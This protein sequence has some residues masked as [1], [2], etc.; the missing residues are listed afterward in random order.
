MKQQYIL[1]AALFTATAMSRGGGGGGS[2]GGGGG[3][4]SRGGGGGGGR[5]SGGRGGDSYDSG[6]SGCI[7]NS[8]CRGDGEKCYDGVC[9]V[10]DGPGNMCGGPD[11]DD[12][13][14]EGF[15]CNDK[16]TRCVPIPGTNPDQGPYDCV[17]DEDC[18]R[19]QI[20]YEGDCVLPDKIP[21]TEAP[22][23]T[24]N[25]MCGEAELCY[26][27]E[28]Q[29]DYGLGNGNM[30]GG[31][32]ND[33]PCFECFECTPDEESCKPIT[34]CDAS[35]CFVDSDCERGQICFQNDCA[36]PDK[37]PGECVMIHGDG[38]GC[39]GLEF[40]DCESSKSCEWAYDSSEEYGSD[41]GDDGDS[42]YEEESSSEGSGYEEESE[43][44]DSGYADEECQK[45]C[46]DGFE[47]VKDQYG[48]ESCQRV[49]RRGGAQELAVAAWESVH[50]V[51]S[52][53]TLLLVSVVALTVIF[54]AYRCVKQ[55]KLRKEVESTLRAG[56][57]ASAE[58]ESMY[59]QAV[60]A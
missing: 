45:K 13:C 5:N 40:Y 15:E 46:M 36:L 34:D 56:E 57:D 55:M 14:F 21:T 43:S 52:S 44:S 23:C 12:V 39:D 16:E 27:G 24:S 59:Y 54:A 19:K 47:C 2:R 53:T 29:L 18:E 30:C 7:Q 35:W 9:E 49:S 25:S 1:L 4:G 22:P 11:G 58:A 42:G 6:D 33:E 17:F 28:C 50:G 20:C 26:F 32:W 51:N 31:K 8:Q 37:I 38:K 10:N 48:E 3:G 60:S 41:G